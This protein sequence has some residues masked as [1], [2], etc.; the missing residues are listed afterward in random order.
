MPTPTFFRAPSTSS[1][2]GLVLANL[3]PLAGVIWF[4]WDLFGIMW[5]YWAENAVIGVFGVLRIIT[6]GEIQHWATVTGRTFLAAFFCVHY[7][8]FWF[9]HGV[10]VYAL[11]GGGRELEGAGMAALSGVPIE[12]LVPLVVSHGASF[13]MN[14]LVGGESR[15]TSGP[16]EMTKPYGRVVVLHVAILGGGFLLVAAGGAVWALALFIVLKT[17]LDLGI[18]LKGHQMRLAKS[19]ANA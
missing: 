17:A 19:E 16:A 10:F 12:G 7:G 3:V 6:A 8:F 1:A 11:F 15:S 9:V 5:L 2:V 4:G 18:H 13:V 14:Y